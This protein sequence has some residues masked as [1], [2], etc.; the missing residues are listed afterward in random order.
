MQGCGRFIQISARDG[1]PHF[2][3]DLYG[4]PIKCRGLY[5]ER[6]GAERLVRAEMHGPER[7]GYKALN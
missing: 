6:S 3:A 7:F 5:P 2:L 4:F 1:R